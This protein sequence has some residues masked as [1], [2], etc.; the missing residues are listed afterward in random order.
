LVLLSAEETEFLEETRFLSQLRREESF[1][2]NMPNTLQPVIEMKS[3][4]K[5][6]L[7][8][9]ANWDITFTLF[10]GEICALLGENG[11]GKTTLMNILFGYYSCDEGEIFIQGHKVALTSPKDAIKRGVK[12]IHQ[13]FTLVPS[14][15]VLENIMIGDEPGNRFFPGLAYNPP[16][17]PRKRG[18]VCRSAADQQGG[19]VCRSMAD[20]QRGEVCRSADDRLVPPLA[21]GHRGVLRKSWF[22]DFKAARQKLLNLQEKFGLAI[23]PDAKVWTLSIGEQQK[24]EIL[25]ALY[26]DAQILI[27]DEPTAVL[28]PAEVD[29]L[30]KMLRAYVQEGN[31]VVFISH[32]L[33]EVMEI[34]DRIVVLRNGEVTAERKTAE[35]NARELANLMVGRDVLERIERRKLPTGKPILEIANLSVLNDK[36][37]TAVKNVSLVVSAKE[38]LGIAGVSGNGQRELAEVLF[39]IR[40][41]VAGEVQVNQR[42]LQPGSP[43]AAIASGMGRIPEDRMA[44]GLLMDLSVEENLVLEN[45][46]ASDFQQ[47]GLRNFP[48]IH[49]FSEQLI[50]T[51]NIKTASRDA[52]VKSLSGGNLQKVILARE[53]SGQPS[54]IIAAQPTRGLDVGAMEFIHA[55]IL[56]EKDRGAA[57]ILI[58]EDLD[59]IMML[60]DRIAVMYEGEILGEIE[61][62]KADREQI[63]LWMSGVRT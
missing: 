47:G 52:L 3:I 40:T 43:V 1:Q 25:K 50:R 58:S 11:A 30:F 54:L 48:N 20:Q 37:L 22:L 35:T 55:R 42:P 14:H 5:R 19:K 6:F 27:M 39:G 49:Q 8:V 36:K 2:F 57:V 38:V 62:E 13:H 32:K 59:E 41:P 53:L 46:R 60:S 56:E 26:R 21:G 10:P 15:S 23:D 4:T 31:A 29:E 63:G 18:E 28:V 7:D 34:S 44:T 12:M 16:Q 45:H 51:Y 9:T 33:N 24:V 17:S 61:A